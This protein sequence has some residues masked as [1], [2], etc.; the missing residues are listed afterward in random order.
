MQTHT[1]EQ[2]EEI[3]REHGLLALYLFGSCA[4]DGLSVL[5]GGK[6]DTVKF[7]LSVGVVFPGYEPEISDDALDAIRADLEEVLTP[8]R[9]EVVPLQQLDCLPE[10]DAI[11]YHRV[12][13][14]DPVSADYYE[15]YVARRAAEFQYFQRREERDEEELRK[16]CEEILAKVPEDVPP[17]PGDEL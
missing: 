13:A 12:A 2:T 9:V 10:W 5:Q 14:P 3:C 16:R 15:L 1:F 6:P 17:D 7:A 8:L 11:N 4:D